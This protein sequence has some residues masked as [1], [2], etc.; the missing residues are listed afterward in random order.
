MCLGELVQV[1]AV[2][3]SGLQAR[4]GRRTV[5]VCALT[6][7]APAQVGDWL[8]VHAGFALARIDAAEA[9][10]ALLLREHDI[11]TTAREPT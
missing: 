7:D 10:A 2:D 3:D 1:T 6:L 5:R 8:L 4:D 11:T 9:A